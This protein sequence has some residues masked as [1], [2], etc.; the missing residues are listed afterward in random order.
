MNRRILCLA[1][2]ALAV[3]S[4]TS[5]AKAES[6]RAQVTMT[7]NMHFA[8]YAH[9]AVLLPSG[10]VL[11][12]GGRGFVP[13]SGGALQVTSR[14]ELYDPATGEWTETG[15]MRFPRSY[16][17]A[18]LLDNGKV[19]VVGGSNEAVYALDSAEI[20]DPSNGTWSLTGSMNESRCDH[21]AELLQNGK[22]LVFGGWQDY[23]NIQ[24]ASA[25]LYDPIDGTWTTVGSMNERRAHPGSGV[26]DDGRVLAAGGTICCGY[27]DLKSS[28]IFD[29]GTETWSYTGNMNER[30]GGPGLVILPSGSAFYTGAGTDA[31]IEQFDVGT[32]TWTFG[33]PMSVARA[34]HTATLLFNGEVL[35]TGGFNG[36]FAS[37]REFEIYNPTTDSWT[38][39]GFMAVPRRNHEAT[40]LPN[41]RV[42]ITG[43][44]IDS[45]SVTA[46]AEIFTPAVPLVT[47][48]SITS[49]TSS[50]ASGGGNVTDDGETLVTARGICWSTSAN[51]TTANRCTTS[52]S[53]MGPFTSSITGLT[54]S[55]TYHV[56]AYAINSSGTAYGEDV[57]FITLAPPDFQV[58]TASGGSYSSTVTA[59]SSAVYNLAA[60]GINGFSG[61]V[62]FA[63]SGLPS[64]TTCSVSPSPLS[65][66]GS[67][68]VPFTVT[69][70]TTAQTKV[71]G[72]TTDRSHFPSGRSAPAA[73]LALSA[74]IPMMCMPRRQRLSVAFLMLCV[75]GIA[76]CGGS[77]KTTSSTTPGTPAG[78]YSIVLSAMSGSISHNTNL[79]LTVK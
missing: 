61:S 14:A 1:L 47:T 78:T 66:S 36:S 40:L 35:A 7:G 12:A 20:Y 62:S 56:R 43:G 52:G 19:L 27:Q 34:W 37:F 77:K 58:S 33:A 42:L 45:N 72:V 53:G 44:E 17:T 51:P 2:A 55:T 70:K 54:S 21:Q 11:V 38:S 63:C 32:G 71:A 41:G 8:R 5:D 75:V 60:A 39:P 22:V 6:T 28:E 46:S 68:A 69:I 31:S 24:L 67:A 9:I 73:L 50:A 49:I 30:R 57:E 10:K 65:V 13:G 59:G 25:E 23:T 76:G 74:L 26:L 16:Y 4:L 48:A 15:S 3:I 64:K 18:T 79:T 29:P